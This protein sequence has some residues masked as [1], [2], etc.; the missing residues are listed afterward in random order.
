MI[1]IRLASPAGIRP[2]AF[3]SCPDPSITDSPQMHKP[4]DLNTCAL[5]RYVQRVERIKLQICV[6]HPDH[7]L[8]PQKRRSIP[9]EVRDYSFFNRLANISE[10]RFHFLVTG[11]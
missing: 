11:Y 8:E 10:T 6:E 3:Y 1:L 2:L 7:N 9:L 4:W 5:L